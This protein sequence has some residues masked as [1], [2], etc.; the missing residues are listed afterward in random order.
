MTKEEYLSI[1]STNHGKLLYDTYIDKHDA[2][3][4]GPLLDFHNFIHFLNMSGQLQ[5]VLNDIVKEHDIKYEI[6]IVYDKNG[7]QIRVL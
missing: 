6:V 3:K 5:R 7:Q 2:E 4:H 1:R